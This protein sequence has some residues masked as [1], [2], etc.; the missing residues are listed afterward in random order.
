MNR[1][2][3]L[4]PTDGAIGMALHGRVRQPDCMHAW[5]SHVRLRCL[6][7]YLD[8]GRVLFRS[9]IDAHLQDTDRFQWPER[10]NG[11]ARKPEATRYLG[12][13]AALAEPYIDEVQ[14]IFTNR[15]LNTQQIELLAKLVRGDGNAEF[16]FHSQYL[17]GERIEK[18][19]N[20][21]G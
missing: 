12:P 20:S 11:I 16:T 10:R 13:F 15:P 3:N 9:L 4:G 18:V 21:F 2:Q 5:V 17:L 7:S 1:T 6:L 19:L 14:F 8:L